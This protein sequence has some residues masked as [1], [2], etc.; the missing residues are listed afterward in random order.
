VRVET[1]ALASESIFT[2]RL[3]ARR[4]QEGC[5]R[6][7]S[8]DDLVSITP[9]RFRCQ[10][11]LALARRRETL[12][13]E[14]LPAVEA[15]RIRGRLRPDFSSVRYGRP[16]YAQLARTI[17][18]EIRTGAG[19]GSEMGAF[20]HLKQPQR[21]ANLRIRLDEYLP[22]GLAAGSIHVT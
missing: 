21:E 7:S 22:Y 4:R 20:E 10:P 9:R 8:V 16:G 6:Y 2:G 19:D 17:A 11:D 3:I 14:S 15:S 12:G 5:V 18:E 1:L 13:V